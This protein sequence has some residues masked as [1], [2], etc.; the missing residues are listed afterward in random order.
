MGRS[1]AAPSAADLVRLLADQ[2]EALLQR[3]ANA[4]DRIE[5]CSRKLEEALAGLAAGAGSAAA[6]SRSAGIAPSPG[7]GLSAAELARLQ[8]ELQATQA[9]LSR[10]AAGNRRAL[11]TL[12]GEASL[13]SR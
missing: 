5:A 13:Y 12:F 1:G 2:R 9:T 11:D 4:P 6:A 7:H 3:G 10:V 8:D